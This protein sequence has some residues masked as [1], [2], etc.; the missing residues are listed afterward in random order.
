MKGIKILLLLLCVTGMLT[1]CEKK[2][3]ILLSIENEEVPLREG[4]VYLK[5]A[6]DDFE[7]LGG[8]DIWK[9]SL[10]G[11]DAVQ[12][13]G[14]RALQSLVRTKVL[15]REWTG[16]VTQE[17]QLELE[18]MRGQLEEA[19]GKEFCKQWKITEEVLERVLRESFF[20]DQYQT[21]QMFTTNQ[22]E[23]QN[24]VDEAFAWYDNTDVEA[25]LQK[26][27]LLPLMV[28]TGEWADGTW[29]EYPEE[30]K[31]EKRAKIQE[32]YGRLEAGEDFQEV[33]ARFGEDESASDN[34][35]LNEGII[36]AVGDRTA[37]YRGQIQPDLAERIFRIPA[38]EHTDIISVKYGFIIVFVL[39]YPETAALD[40]RQYTAQLEI[41]KKQYREDL[42][43]GFQL[44]GF[45]DLYEQIEQRTPI[46]IDEELWTKAVA[47]FFVP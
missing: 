2:E 12:T 6:A 13:V 45:N 15:A 5:L 35:L 36:R 40:R 33:A 16:D 23:L 29:V 4:M 11:K 24:K 39:E 20:A 38:N 43:A 44:R 34:R 9:I 42:M 18:A 46:R 27:R 28:Y 10:T 7:A 41:A 22:E 47:D 8:Q 32:A 3:D 37:F 30:R 25:Y 31:E 17:E 19:L 14:E 26:V 21:S 1:G